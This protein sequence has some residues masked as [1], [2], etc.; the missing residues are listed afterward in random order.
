[1][2]FKSA[3]NALIYVISKLKTQRLL[4]PLS[5]RNNLWVLIKPSY[6]KG[7]RILRIN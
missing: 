6:L 5:G 1:M 4:R 2:G 3:Q 7:D